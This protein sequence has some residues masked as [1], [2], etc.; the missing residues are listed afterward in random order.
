MSVHLQVLGTNDNKA[1]AFYWML[2]HCKNQVHCFEDEAY[3][4]NDKDYSRFKKQKFKHKEL[5]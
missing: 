3:I 4:M 2:N 1:K 5:I